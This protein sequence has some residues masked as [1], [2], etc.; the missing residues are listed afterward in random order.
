MPEKQSWLTYES[1]DFA[2]HRKKWMYIADHLDG[3][4]ID[5][6]KVRRYLHKRKQGE[7]DEAYWER[8]NA[9]LDY[10]PLLTRGCLTLAGMLWAVEYDARRSW[11]KDELAEGLG[12]PKADGTTMSILYHNADGKGTNWPIVWHEA[13]IAAIAYT[14]FFVLVDGRRRGKDNQAVSHARVRLFPPQAVPRP[15]YDDSGRLISCKIKH[16]TDAIRSQREESKMVDRYTI[17]YEDGFEHWTEDDDGNPVQ[18][19]KRTPYGGSENPDFRYLDR[20]R[21]TPILPI[22]EVRMPIPGNLGYIMAKKENAIFNQNSATD[23]QMYT[24]GFAKLFA[25]VIDKDGKFD[26]ARFEAIVAQFKQGSSI[27]PGAENKYSAAPTDSLTAK[28]KILEEK[29]R[30][31]YTTFFQAYGDA[32]SE[33]TATEIRQDFRAGVEAFLTLLSSTIDEA[34]NGA[35]WRLEQIYFPD[36]PRVWGGASVKRSTNFQPVDIEA[37][38]EGL[39]TRYFPGGRIPVDID[40]MLEIAAKAL[41]VDGFPD[42]DDRKAR[43]REKFEQELANDDRRRS[44][45]DAFGIAA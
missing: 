10:T 1:P 39:V 36:R 8:L 38:I 19:G 9:I 35:L 18:V 45:E 28:R 29:T 6:D 44:L 34:E 40:T 22:F 31:F 12:D 33:R 43:L 32:A 2:A 13:T 37:R 26:K 20:D 21:R 41:E 15:I 16:R 17:F 27:I 4:I 11:S 5:D 14:R 23:F 42:T 30:E 25:D 3:S 24:S 7:T